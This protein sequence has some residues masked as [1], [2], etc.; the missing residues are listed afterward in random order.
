MKEQLD[1]SYARAGVSRKTEFRSFRT[2]ANALR[3][4]DSFRSGR[5]A[6]LNHIDLASLTVDLNPFFRPSDGPKIDPVRL[7]VGTKLGAAGPKPPAAFLTILACVLRKLTSTDLRLSC[8][9]RATCVSQSPLEDQREINQ[10]LQR[11]TFL[12]S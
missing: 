11:P 2:S 4:L 5:V 6:H 1:D 3:I 10:A 8:G 9:S 7:L 12:P